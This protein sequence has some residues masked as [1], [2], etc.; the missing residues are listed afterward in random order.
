MRLT[1]EQ[2]ETYS[3]EDEDPAK[4]W[5]IVHAAERE[6]RLRRTHHLA[7]SQSERIIQHLDMVIAALG[8]ALVKLGEGLE[9]LAE[10]DHT[11][12]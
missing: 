8:R 10:R 9:H 4:V 1:R 6:G 3:E 11:R 2:A 5:A 7:P 12:T